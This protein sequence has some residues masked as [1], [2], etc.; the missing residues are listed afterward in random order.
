MKSVEKLLESIEQSKMQPFRKVLFALGI[1]HIGEGMSKTLAQYFGSIEALQNADLTQL[2]EIKEVG[3]SI[4][5]S[6]IEFFKDEHEMIML[7]ALKDAGVCMNIDESEMERRTE[8][9]VGYSFVLT[10]ELS[11][12]TRQ[13]ASEEIEKRGGKVIGSVSKKTT[14]LIAG[15]QAGSKLDKARELNIPILTEQDF[16][17]VIQGR[18]PL[19]SFLGL[20]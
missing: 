3:N 10:G 19:I 7:N 14:C 11:A 6:L 17:A 15:E 16:L 5:N 2:L 1:R 12:L 20:P 13:E 4:T 8:E 18:L 9:F